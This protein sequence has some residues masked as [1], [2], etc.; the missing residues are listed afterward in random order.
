MRWLT[1]IV[2]SGGYIYASPSCT[3]PSSGQTYNCPPGYNCLPCVDPSA[4]VAS[5]GDIIGSCNCPSCMVYKMSHLKSIE[6]FISRDSAIRQINTLCSV[7]CV[8][9]I[10]AKEFSNLSCRDDYKILGNTVIFDNVKH[11][12]IF[13]ADGYLF[14][15][16]FS[17]RIY[18]KSGLY[19]LN[20][21][22][23]IVKVLIK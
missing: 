6:L 4:C 21:D 23:K 22:G 5:N 9:P 17:S 7:C 18:M 19:I 10:E 12:K 20:Y 15:E 2:I 16:G 11:Y 3:C 14:D 13:K 8:P 1:L